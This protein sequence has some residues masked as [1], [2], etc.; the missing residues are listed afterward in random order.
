[1]NDPPY[2]D[3]Q[4]RMYR[5]ARN[6]LNNRLSLYVPIKDSSPQLTIY[7]ASQVIQ[8]RTATRRPSCKVN[9][10]G[11]GD[12]LFD[13]LF[14]FSEETRVRVLHQEEYDQLFHAGIRPQRGGRDSSL[15]LP[16]KW[17]ECSSDLLNYLGNGQ[18]RATG[19]WIG[20]CE[21]LKISR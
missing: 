3:P 18:T 19:N 14:D 16:M 10:S 20:L 2:Y 6:R 5:I 12:I 7:K 11:Y 13:T 9:T 15:L 21:K 17:I 4:P 1:M 8:G